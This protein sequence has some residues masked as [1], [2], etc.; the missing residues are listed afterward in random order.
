MAVGA[1]DIPVGIGDPNYV[2]F[3]DT[4]KGLGCGSTKPG[5]YPGSTVGYGWT[6]QEANFDGSGR[7]E[8][9]NCGAGD[10]DGTGDGNGDF[11]GGGF[12]NRPGSGRGDYTFY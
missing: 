5:G 6:Y 1:G 7:R 11:T 10:K 9:G 12:Y 3:A 8:I 2:R 4:P